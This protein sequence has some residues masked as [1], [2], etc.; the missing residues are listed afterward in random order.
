MITV[1]RPRP[2]AMPRA[3]L[4]T[5]EI[6]TG[7]TLAHTSAGGALPDLP[8]LVALAG[9][10]FAASVPVVTGRASLPWMLAGVGTAQLGI[11]VLLTLMDP[12]QDHAGHVHHANAAG[13]P[14][15]LSWQMAA[16]HAASALITAAVWRLRRRLAELVLAV[17]G[18]TLS[19][20]DCARPPGVRRSP[21]AH[22]PRLWL[23]GAPRRGPPAQLRCA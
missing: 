19:L 13:A 17:P 12:A 8:W 11:H 2:R 14:L 21:Q 1:P 18:A 23:A 3:A 20:P 7:V 6:M 22:A 5:A 16:A 9:V 4:A 15:E 10:V